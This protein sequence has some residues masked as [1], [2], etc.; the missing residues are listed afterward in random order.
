MSSPFLSACCHIR[1]TR[2]TKNPG[3]RKKL[4][5]FDWLKRVDLVLFAGAD[6]LTW[7][8]TLSAV[9]TFCFLFLC[10]ITFC[11]P[12]IANGSGSGSGSGLEMNTSGDRLSLSIEASAVR[13]PPP[14]VGGPEGGSGPTR[15]RTRTCLC[16]CLSWTTSGCRR[17][18]SRGSAATR[19]SSWTRPPLGDPSGAT[20]C[21]GGPA[22]PGGQSW[23]WWHV[24]ARKEPNNFIM[25]INKSEY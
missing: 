25:R 5:K 4:L 22:P 9:S 14:T 11:R 1:E 17:R 23:T 21:P 8:G 12:G 19:T 7:R 15:T 6:F 24:R 3:G 16:L 20:S 13:T 2:A 10:S 18:S